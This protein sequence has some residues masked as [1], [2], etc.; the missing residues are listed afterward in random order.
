MPPCRLTPCS[1]ATAGQVA[2][3]IV[4]PA[5]TRPVF[6]GDTIHVSKRLIGTEVKT[7]AMGMLAFGYARHRESTRSDRARVRGPAA[8]QAGRA[9]AVAE[10]THR[11]LEAAVSAG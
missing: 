1:N 3:E 9:A 10:T 7:Q 8:G 2:F 4:A 5:V 6:I 11:V